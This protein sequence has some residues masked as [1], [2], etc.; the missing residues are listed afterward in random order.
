MKCVCFS[1][2]DGVWRWT[3]PQARFLE[4]L[5]Q[6]GDEVIYLYCD[7][8]M[9][10]YC[11]TMAV[12]GVAISDSADKKAAVCTECVRTSKLVRERYAF[13][14]IPL[15]GLV[16]ENDIAMADAMSRQDSVEKLIR[17]SAAGIP[18]GQIA[19]Y[20][21]VIQ[22][23]HVTRKIDGL[24]EQIYR[25]LFRNSIIVATA[26]AR[27]L[28]RQ[29]PDVC[30]SYHTAYAYNR[31]FQKVAESAGV[32]V[33]SLSASFNMEEHDS[34]LVVS[35]GDP[36]Q[37][38][39]KMMSAWPEF[40]DKVC[41]EAEINAAA[42]HLTALMAGRGLAYSVPVGT[43]TNPVADSGGKMVLVILSSYDE[44][45]A[46]ELA[47]FG[48]STHNEIFASQVIWIEWLFQ[49]AAKRPDVKFVIR[50]HPREF[51]IN[52][53]GERSAHVDQLLEVFADRPANVIINMPSDRIPIYELM[54]ESD[55]VMV[56]WSS[57]GMEAGMLG[58][59]VVTYFGDAL[60][61]PPS[62]LFD[63]R[64]RLQYGEMIDYALSYGWSF[65]RA[66]AFFRWG[67][68]SLVRARIRVTNE[69]YVSNPVVRTFKRAVRYARRRLTSW[70]DQEWQIALSRQRLEER[71]KIYRLVDG[72]LEAFYS[73]PDDGECEPSLAI[74]SRALIGA[75]E[76]IASTYEKKSKRRS[77]KLREL[78]LE[79]KAANQDDIEKSR[80]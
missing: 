11:M 1:P 73:I 70:S 47:A 35:K 61:Y 23:K 15:H 9:S 71:E 25:A 8:T 39:K 34:H 51:P 40:K 45:L 42:T 24:A 68:L 32:P 75:L 57:A 17:Y 64:S 54:L 4:A 29:R 48:W 3:F 80:P 10:E 62:L 33:Y 55:L 59:P 41:S 46:S 58:I 60:L 26:T 66:R 56:A 20:E 18:V 78:I 72:R 69:G 74:E 65:E 30:A 7:K 14:G 53:K 76:G 63:A 43:G 22:S 77:R 27:L 79:A 6:R 12:H 36:E 19:L 2:N 16:D 52:G 49:Y 5:K 50:V 13:S 37:T 38:F 67:V 28:E 31:T 44:L 21:A